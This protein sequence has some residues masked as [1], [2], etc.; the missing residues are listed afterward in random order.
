MNKEEYIIGSELIGNIGF[1]NTNK[2][3]IPMYHRYFYNF[4]DTYLRDNTDKV[5]VQYHEDGIEPMLEVL[6]NE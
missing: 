4:V 5:Y 2:R 1:I 3:S 6:D